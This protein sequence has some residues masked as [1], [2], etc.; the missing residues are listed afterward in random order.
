MVFSALEASTFLQWRTQKFC[1]RGVQQFHLRTESRENGDLGGGSPWSGVLLN[2][3]SGSTLSNF[4]DVW[5]Y[6]P[7]N[8]E[9][10]SAL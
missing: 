6:F 5:M 7:W 9:L 4:W 3:Q 8:W 10:G 1:L 2:L